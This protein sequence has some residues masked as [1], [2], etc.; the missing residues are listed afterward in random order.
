MLAA[1]YILQGKTVDVITTSAELIDPEVTHQAHFFNLLNLTVAANC[2][3]QIHTNSAL[4]A[5]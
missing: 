1:A 4:K 5:V 3:N 2:H